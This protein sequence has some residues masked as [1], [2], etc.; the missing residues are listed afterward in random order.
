MNV[1]E[2]GLKAVEDFGPWATTLTGMK[3]TL[4]DQG[5]SD[6]GAEYMVLQT[7]QMGMK[8]QEQQP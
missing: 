4:M 2:Q 6:Q 1:W 5:W 7:L 3:R 8:M